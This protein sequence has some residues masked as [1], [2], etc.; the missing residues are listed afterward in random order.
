MTSEEAIYFRKKL[1][2]TQKELCDVV[3]YSVGTVK[4]W[5]NGTIK[6]PRPVEI[7]FGYIQKYEMGPLPELVKSLDNYVELRIQEENELIWKQ[8]NVFRKRLKE[9]DKEKLDSGKNLRQSF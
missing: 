6:V 1:G 3:G 7:I 4:R 9:Q 2:V 5:E 8:L